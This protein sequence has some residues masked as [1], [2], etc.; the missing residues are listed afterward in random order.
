MISSILVNQLEEK[1][2]GK[3]PGNQSHGLMLEQ[4]L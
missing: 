1:N 4:V 3:P 2:P